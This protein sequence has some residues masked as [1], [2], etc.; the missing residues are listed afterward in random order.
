MDTRRAGALGTAGLTSRTDI[1]HLHSLQTVTVSATYSER[2]NSELTGHALANAAWH[3]I[4]HGAARN[5]RA[6]KTAHHGLN[7]AEL[8]A[9]IRLVP[10]HKVP[11]GMGRADGKRTT[12]GATQKADR[13]NSAERRI[14]RFFAQVLAGKPGLPPDRF[15]GQAFAR[16]ALEHDPEKWKPIFRKDHAPTKS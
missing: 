15:R 1:I 5:R 9:K 12:H 10:A 2:D 4:G 3:P 6:N 14:L 11:R 8:G 7:A 16:H 13:A